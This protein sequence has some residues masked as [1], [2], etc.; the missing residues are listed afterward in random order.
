MANTA[1][2]KPMQQSDLQWLFR[3][4]KDY[5]PITLVVGG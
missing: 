5:Q 3:F 2:G 4:P 1:D